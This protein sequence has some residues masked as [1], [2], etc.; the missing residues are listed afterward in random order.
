MYKYLK[1]NIHF[2]VHVMNCYNSKIHHYVCMFPAI[3]ALHII[4]SSLKYSYFFLT[5]HPSSH[6]CTDYLF[7]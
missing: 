6:Q 3:H 2:L 4:I 1:I 5:Q 7:D